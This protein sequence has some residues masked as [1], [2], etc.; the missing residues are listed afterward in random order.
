MVWGGVVGLVLSGCGSSGG[1]SAAT[2]PTSAATVVAD[3]SAVAATTCAALRTLDNELVRTV[4]RSVA[5]INSLA[6]EERM[7]SILQGV[8]AVG[9]VLDDWRTTVEDL[10]LGEDARSAELRRQLRVGADEAIAELA[11]QRRVFEEQPAVIVDREVQGV[12][13]TWFNSVEKVMSVIEPELAGFDDPQFETAFQDEPNCR[14]VI[15]RY[16]VD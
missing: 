16:V 1:E 13:G 12:V 11:R 2:A 6:A 4:N 14:H 7:P 15:Q 8:D 3:V 10:Q 5:S 9:E